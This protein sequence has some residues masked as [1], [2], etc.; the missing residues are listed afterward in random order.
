MKSGRMVTAIIVIATMGP[1]GASVAQDA[2][3]S[4]DAQ[5]QLNR[6]IGADHPA[7]QKELFAELY[8]NADKQALAALK[9]HT[10]PGVAIRTAWEE[11]Y[12][13]NPPENAAEV[14][15]EF[16]ALA[17][18]RF[19]GF[20]EGRLRIQVPDAW[21]QT[22]AA[23]ERRPG[24]RGIFY[25]IDT[26]C[27]YTLAGR[28]LITPG[29]TLDDVAISDGN[30]R[31]VIPPA[32][33]QSHPQTSWHAA[34]VQIESSEWFLAFPQSFDSRYTLYCIGREDQAVRW[35]QPVWASEHEWSPPGGTGY[36]YHCVSIVCRDDA[37]TVFGNS[38]VGAYIEV[39]RRVD[40]TPLMRFCTMR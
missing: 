37:V 7:A 6:I 5:E 14:T 9:G 26:D 17:L 4:P 12:Q 8:R 24:Q 22:I 21:W 39:F 11:M 1:A 13:R 27:R 25:R 28:T 15:R 34:C 2:S 35:S 29:M 36:S 10:D 3:E 16:G 31:V 23:A 40:G 38:G 30:S 20:V 18:E 33:M 19:V 32:V